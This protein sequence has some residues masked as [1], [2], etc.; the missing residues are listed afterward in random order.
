MDGGMDAEEALRRARRLEP[1]HLALSSAHGLMGV[2]G[3]I[4][5]PDALLVGASQAKV[6]ERCSIGGELVGRQPLRREALLPE[7]LAHQSKR[8]TLVAP[9]LN[10]HIGR[11]RLAAMPLSVGSCLRSLAPR[12][13]SELGEWL[14]CRAEQLQ[15]DNHDWHGQRK[16]VGAGRDRTSC[17]RCVT[18]ALYR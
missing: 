2:L 14:L 17:L 9:P 4:V 7:E 16:L 3:A 1:L 5:L 6:P 10:Q 12:E 13:C 8:R 15:L 11:G 18:A